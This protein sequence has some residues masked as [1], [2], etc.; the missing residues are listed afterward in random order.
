VKVPKKVVRL[1]KKN[2]KV[3][4]VRVDE[5]TYK[6]LKVE[7]KRLGLTVNKLVLSMFG[8]YLS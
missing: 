5:V 3:I 1:A 7:A 2:T 4:F 8:E 6:V